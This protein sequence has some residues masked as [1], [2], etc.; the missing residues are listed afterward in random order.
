MNP[1]HCFVFDTNA[2][3]SALLF[4]QSVP[5]C[6]FFAAAGRGRILLSQQTLAELSKVLQRKKFDRYLDRDDRDE[7]LSKLVHEATFVD[8][9]EEIHVCRDPKDDKVLELAV[10]GSATCV[11]TGDEDLLVLHPFRG[12]PIM[13]PAQFLEWISQQSAD[14]ES[15]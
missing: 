3:V 9:I 1:E 4:D 12:I 13:T 5:A 11:V 10:G 7:F 14:D 8:V 6:A 2:P 15:P